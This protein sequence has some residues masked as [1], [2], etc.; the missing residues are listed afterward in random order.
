MPSWLQEAWSESDSPRLSASSRRR[1]LW[2]LEPVAY[3]RAVPK[4]SGGCT[5]SWARRPSLELHAGFGLALASTRATSGMGGEGL[6]DRRRIGCGGEK[7]EIADGRAHA[8]QAAGGFSRLTPGRA[9]RNAS[10]S[11][12]KGQA[13]PSGMRSVRRA[14]ASMPGDDARFGFLAHAGQ[15]AQ[16]AGPGGGFQLRQVGD[17]QLLPEQGDFLGSQVGHLQQLDQGGRDLG[18]E[19][20]EESQ[21]A[22]EE[23]LVDLL[24]DGLA[25]AGDLGQLAFSPEIEG[26]TA[27]VVQ[28]VGGFA[29]G[30]DLVDHLAL[31]LEQIGDAGENPGE[32]LVGK[33]FNRFGHRS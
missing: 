32:V 11:W 20:L 33:G 12:A 15:A 28:A 9:R 7:V 19:L 2:S 25:D 22:G 30:Q 21:L 24:G 31:D 14:R 17:A 23:K 6:H 10:R 27:Q 26:G 29:V 3:C 5:Q 18:L 1:T 4:R 16:L 13:W 8:A